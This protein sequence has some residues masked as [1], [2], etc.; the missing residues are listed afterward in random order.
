MKGLFRIAMLML[1]SFVFMSGGDPAFAADATADAAATPVVVVTH[2]D[3]ERRNLDPALALM[4]G[5]VATTRREPGLQHIELLAQVGVPN[6]FTVV[7]TWADQAAYDAHTGSQPIRDFR[8]RID[9]FLGS[10]YDDRLHTEV[11]VSQP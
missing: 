10:P 6:H 1:A 2:L 4:R 7:E 3:I 8:N 11:A 9:P 5:Y